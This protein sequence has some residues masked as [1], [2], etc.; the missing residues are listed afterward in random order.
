MK[1]SGRGAGQRKR[2]RALARMP[3]A[4]AVCMALQWP[5]QALAQAAGAQD[6]ATPQSQDEPRTLGKVTVTAQRALPAP[7][8]SPL[9][10]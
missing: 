7:R 8:I 1:T 6:T 5:A 10:P 2:A 3:L 4:V 9:S